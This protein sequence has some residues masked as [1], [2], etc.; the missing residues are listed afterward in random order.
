MDRGR[1]K[2]LKLLFGTL[3]SQVL[4]KPASAVKTGDA[5]IN[6]C[7]LAISHEYGAIVQ[8]INHSGVISDHKLDSVFMM[9]MK[10][11]IVHA[12]SI[13]E[14]VL[15]EGGTPTVGIWPPQT[16]K[17]PVTLIKEDIAGETAAINLYQQILDMPESRKFRDAVYKFLRNE[18]EHRKRLK[19][20]L[21]EFSEKPEVKGRK[22][23]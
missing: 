6:L 12:R 21:K 20:L 19:K 10:D 7:N 14:F 13:T 16:G 22:A 3:A 15:K 23:L 18:I 11:E 9:N 2:A 4:I 5:F 8:Y 17:D 1:R